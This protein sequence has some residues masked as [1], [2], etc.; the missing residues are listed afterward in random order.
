MSY[1]VLIEDKALK[2]IAELPAPVRAQVTA[3]ID[4]LA[5]DPRPPRA[6]ALTGGLRGRLKLRVRDW[7]VVYEVDDEQRRV[8]VTRIRHRS[9]AYR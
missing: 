1:R 9:K 4:A 8:T 5:G 3:Q 7:R 6:E 2:A